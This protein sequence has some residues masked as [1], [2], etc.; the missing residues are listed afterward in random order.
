[1]EVN[2]L[3]ENEIL[4]LVASE[5]KA[6]LRWGLAASV[7]NQKNFDLTN[8]DANFTPAKKTYSIS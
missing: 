4:D 3:N 5:W 7:S 6:Y 2:Q 1:M 8:D